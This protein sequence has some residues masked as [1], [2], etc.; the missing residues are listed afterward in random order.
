MLDTS[1]VIGW[2]ERGNERVLQE[3]AKAELVP[4]VH[5]VTVGELVEGCERVRPSAGEPSSAT[6][7]FHRRQRVHDFV[8]GELVIA[9]APTLKDAVIFGK[10]SAIVG[11][12]LSHNDKWIMAAALLGGHLLVTEDAAIAVAYESVRFQNLAVEVGPTAR[13]STVALV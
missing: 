3:I 7:V 4:C 2:L 11:R 12:S 1:A 5:L 6:A 8:V 9:P 10:I 13:A